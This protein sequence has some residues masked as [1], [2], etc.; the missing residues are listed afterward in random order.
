MANPSKAL[1]H[2]QPVLTTYEG[3]AIYSPLPHHLPGF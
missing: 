2:N 3:K 1:D